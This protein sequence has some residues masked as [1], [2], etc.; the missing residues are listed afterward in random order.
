MRRLLLIPAIAV[1]QL[2]A[3]TDRATLTGSVTDPAEN[4]IAAARI[5]ITSVATGSV[6]TAASNSAGVFVVGSL[7]VGEYTAS[8]EAKG[9]QTLEFKPFTLRV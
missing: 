2:L 6:Y 5:T 7:P 4:T 9:F 8:I 1:C 3:Q